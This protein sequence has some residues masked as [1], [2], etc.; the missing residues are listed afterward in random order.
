MT[1]VKI[2]SI[3]NSLGVVLPREV[4]QRLRV[5]KG[6]VLYLVETGGGV[7]LVPYEP[8]LVAQIEALERTARADRDVL[9][10][11]AARATMQLPSTRPA[12]TRRSSSAEPKQVTTPDA[13]DV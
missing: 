1:A 3:G 7:E 4:L 6:D 10:G 13:D 8:A 9:L 5:D 11:L 2:T 12:L